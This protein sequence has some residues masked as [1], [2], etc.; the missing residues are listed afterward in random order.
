[1]STIF[2]LVVLGLCGMVLAS[3]YKMSKSINGNVSKDTLHKTVTA[4]TEYTIIND[5]KMKEKD[6]KYDNLMSKHE[7]T[8]E[9]INIMNKQMVEIK[10]ENKEIKIKCN[11]LTHTCSEL[12]NEVAELRDENRRIVNELKNYKLISPN[13]T[14]NKPF[15]AKIIK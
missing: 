5:K 11:K 13:F 7:K 2:M 14:L 15:T 4:L 1:M 8:L 12:Q 6:V 10:N 3:N 9:V